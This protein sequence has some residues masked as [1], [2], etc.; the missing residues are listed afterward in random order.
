V[1][2]L[3]TVRAWCGPTECPLGPPQRR[4]VLAVLA[5]AAGQP[6]SRDELVNTLWPELPP[7]RAVNIIQTHVKHLRQVLEPGRPRRAASTVLPV[8][9]AGYALRIEPTSVDALRFRSLVATAREA[10]R[11]GDATR[12][13]QLA[14]SAIGMWR[15]PV[16]DIPALA[17]HPRVA[18]LVA[19]W[20]LLLG[21]YA[22]VATAQGRADEVVPILEEQAR[23]RPLD[24]PVHV[25]LLRAYA[26]LGRRSDAFAVYAD[27]R[28]R[29]AA[30]L[31]VDAGQDLRSAYDELLHDDATPAAQA[32][33]PADDAPSP[34]AAEPP[35]ELPAPIRDF[36]GRGAQLADIDRAMA[37]ARRAGQAGLVVVVG[38]PGVGKTALGLTW[39]HRMADHFPDGQL[40]VDLRG[41]GAD[42]PLRPVVVLERFLRALDVP[43]QQADPEELAAQFRTHLASRRI[44]VFLDNAA[45]TEQVQPLL[46]GRGG[47]IAIVTSRRRLDGLVALHGA[48][49]ISLGPLARPDA[50]DLITRLT[51]PPAAGS[52]TAP[53]VLAELAELCDRLPLALRIACSRLDPRTGFS[54]GML[55][56]TMAD[57]RTRLDELATESG[58]ISVRAVFATSM[59][60]LD[61]AA[62]RLLRLLSDHPGPRPSLA[63]AAALGDLSIAAA[64]PVLTQL[65]TAHLLTPAGPARYAMHDLVRL[66]A[67]EEAAQTLPQAERDGAMRRLLAWYRDTADSADSQLRPGERP[68][69]AARPPRDVFP[70]EASAHAWLEQEA[71]NLVAA[72]EYATGPYP[73]EA[74]QIAAAMFGWLNRSHNRAQWV[75]LYT[76]AADAAER[77]GDA[78]G[79]AMIAGRLAV[80]YSQQGL[81]A[82]AVAACERAYRIRRDLGDELGAATALLNLGAVYLDHGE[83]EPAVRWLHR[84][85]AQL[86]D[87][88]VEADHFRMLLHSNLGEA[89]RLTGQY[90]VAAHHFNIALEI[91]LGTGKTRDSAQVLV[92]LSRLCLDTA[93]APGA[94][95][96]AHR[97]MDHAGQARDAIVRAEAQECA[98]RALLVKGDPVA[99]RNA[100]TAALMVYEKAGHRNLEALRWL[101]RTPAIQNTG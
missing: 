26:A 36:V 72:V 50:V 60:A 4:S 73:H 41:F 82:E 59:R 86:D 69:F 10:R 63:A 78:T 53:D 49:R 31:G 55:A 62:Q 87:S 6:V 16:A 96:Y 79:A 28:Q 97:A 43:Q 42:A 100:L 9:G 30:D 74:W 14:R 76:L 101:V 5:L 8:V 48:K 40:H 32:I 44:L 92:E 56:S 39:A 17:A 24:E 27:A 2:L 68:N 3:G 23:R 85:A 61:P 29:L 37:G 88:T 34:T 38:P 94:L 35:A 93:D 99:A 33:R 98:G 19:E 51:P 7:A 1:C 80:A 83:P 84:A 57:E 95:E 58:E 65:V 91:G 71:A 20:Q 21:W 66:I 89:H 45:S 46:P 70:H 15:T 22:E 67:R 81:T 12:L 52:R 54:V 64:H 18:A 77:A 47:S 11:A 75:A 25:L 90:A 13:W